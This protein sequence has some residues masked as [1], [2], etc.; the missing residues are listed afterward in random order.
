MWTLP[1]ICYTAGIIKWS[2]CELNQSDIS[3]RKLLA[4]YRCFNVNDDVNRLY[5]SRQG[6]DHG[7]EDTV[8]HERLSLSKHMAC[9]QEPLLQQVF[10]CSQWSFP[11]QSPSKFKAKRKQEYF[12]AWKAKPVYQGD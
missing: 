4:L 8:V 12:D 2:L 1:L 6:V 10:Q 9:S 7:V 11:P 3:T 5:A